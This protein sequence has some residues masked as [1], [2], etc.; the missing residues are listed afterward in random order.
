MV[1]RVTEIQGEGRVYTGVTRIS[2][3]VIHISYVNL[4]TAVSALLFQNFAQVR[5]LKCIRST[6]KEIS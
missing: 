2:D 3:F 1:A 4:Y 5:I 6:G